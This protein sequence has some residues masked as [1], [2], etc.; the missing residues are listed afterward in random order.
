MSLYPKGHVPFQANGLPSDQV[1]VDGIADI[2]QETLDSA[3]GFATIHIYMARMQLEFLRANLF[4]AE[5]LIETQPPPALKRSFTLLPQDIP[6]MLE[7]LKSAQRCL[8]E[9]SESTTCQRILEEYP[10]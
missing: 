6:A 7:T 1:I 4:R 3:L 2:A 10:K 9:W 5:A 8:E